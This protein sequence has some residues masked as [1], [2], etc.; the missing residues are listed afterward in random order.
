MKS[1]GPDLSRLG[2]VAWVLGTSARR[3][4]AAIAT[5]PLASRYGVRISLE[6]CEVRHR[7]RHE[8]ERVS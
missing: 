4:R 5:G 2:R 1:D 7:F 6:R 8:S 3:A